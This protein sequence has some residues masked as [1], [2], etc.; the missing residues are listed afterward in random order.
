MAALRVSDDLL[1]CRHKDHTG[2]YTVRWT[3]TKLHPEPEWHIF[4]ILTS[5][6]IDD[7]IM[8]TKMARK[9]CLN[10]IIKKKFTRWLSSRHCVISPMYLVTKSPAFLQWALPSVSWLLFIIRWHLFGC[11]RLVHAR[12]FPASADAR[13][14]FHLRWRHHGWGGD[15]THFETCLFLFISFGVDF[16]QICEIIF[17]CLS[18]VGAMAYCNSQK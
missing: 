12:W 14:S 7:I 11:A 18:N 1:L 10:Y 3:H 17:N 2:K 5:E 8:R 6:D 16:T 4:H 15:S 9:F 13:R